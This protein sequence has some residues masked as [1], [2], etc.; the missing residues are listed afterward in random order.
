MEVNGSKVRD[1][2]HEE[3]V[4]FIR[5]QSMDDGKMGCRVFNNGIQNRFLA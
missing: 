3:L 1:M 5:Q 4:T 2:P